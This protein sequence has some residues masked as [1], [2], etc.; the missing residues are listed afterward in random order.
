M[1]SELA[2][3]VKNNTPLFCCRYKHQYY[4]KGLNIWPTEFNLD[5][6][7]GFFITTLE[8]VPT[9][10]S[11]ND[12]THCALITVPPDARGGRILS[13]PLDEINEYLVDQVIVEQ[14]F[15]IS[16]FCKKYAPVE[17]W[18]LEYCTLIDQNE[19]FQ[20]IVSKNPRLFHKLSP[21]VVAHNISFCEGLI[22]EN[23]S[24]IQS[25]NLEQ[26]LQFFKVI[27]QVVKTEFW[28]FS[29]IDEELIEQLYNISFDEE[30]IFEDHECNYLYFLSNVPVKIQSKNLGLVRKILT[31]NNEMIEY[32]DKDIQRLV[33]ETIIS[34]VQNK[35]CY[36]EYIDDQFFTG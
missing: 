9:I 32:C 4:I 17:P 6:D 1:D 30:F 33:P 15:E 35:P 13:K 19:I 25:M 28:V 29:I 7:E 24:I 20:P 8:D 5:E 16:K 2:K 14:D 3:V 23:P 21:Q 34:I 36:T 22:K 10:I 12:V 26:Q 27:E 11:W 18:L 31:R